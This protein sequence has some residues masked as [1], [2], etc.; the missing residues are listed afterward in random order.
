MGNNERYTLFEHTVI[1][2]YD[3]KK[4]DAEVLDKLAEAHRGTDIDYGGSRDLKTSDGLS[5]PEVI[6]C[7]KSPDKYRELKETFERLLREHPEVLPPQYDNLFDEAYY[8][9]QFDAVYAIT[10]GEWGWR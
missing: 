6:L 7:F 8:E 4:L 5:L 1:T 10:S 2:L 3:S 9:P